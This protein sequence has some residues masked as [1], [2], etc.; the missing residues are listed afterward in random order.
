VHGAP[1]ITIPV[2]RS[3]RKQ[4][5]VS[6]SRYSCGCCCQGAVLAGG[7][8]PSLS[9]SLYSLPCFLLSFFSASP[10]LLTFYMWRALFPLPRPA[11]Q[12]MPCFGHCP[13]ASSAFPCLVGRSI[14]L[15]CPM[16]GC[17]RRWRLLPAG[18]AVWRLL[19][20]SSRP[21]SCFLS[22]SV[23]RIGLSAQGTCEGSMRP[24]IES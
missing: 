5:A 3:S 13:L 23:F 24:R 1:Q 11:P 17:C 22:H 4:Q 6:S 12:S 2:R 18:M 19:P 7:G 10:S 14:E 21:P 16:A 20:L 9:Y 8:W 15:V